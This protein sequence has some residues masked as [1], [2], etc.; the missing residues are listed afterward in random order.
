MNTIVTGGPLGFYRERMPQ[1]VDRTLATLCCGRERHRRV[2]QMPT[3]SHKITKH[4]TQTISCGAGTT[5]LAEVH[6][7]EVHC[8]GVF[9]GFWTW[10]NH[11]IRYQRCGSNG[12]AVIAIHGFGGNCDHWRKNIAELGTKHR[13]YSLDLLGYG[14]SSKPDPRDLEV[15]SLYNFDTW[16][17]QILDFAKEVAGPDE[18]VFLTCNSVGGIAG[19][20][21]AIKAPERV[22]SVQVMNISLRMLHEKKQSDIAKPFVSALQKTLRTT[23]LGSWFFS[24]IATEKGVRNVLQQCYCDKTTVTDELVDA[25]L[26]PGLQDGAVDVFLDFISYSSGPLPEEQMARCPVPVSVVWGDA[27]PWEKVEWGRAFQKFNC[28]EEFIELPGVGHCPQDEAPHLVNPI[29]ERWIDRH[30]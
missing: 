3:L 16:S 17:D 19:L 25:I 26:K 29:I 9:Q 13:V 18:K 27:D 10:R 1:C 28:V 5:S 11:S 14:Y 7:T 24:Q 8:P 20:E 23:P 2:T 22:A 6:E 30:V 21:A 4:K 12:P 15:N